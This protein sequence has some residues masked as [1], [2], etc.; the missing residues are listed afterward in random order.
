MSL[1]QKGIRS[2]LVT[3]NM[4]KKQTKDWKREKPFLSSALEARHAWFLP[5]ANHPH[6]ERG[7][8]LWYSVQAAVHEGGN[9]Y[10]WQLFWPLY[11]C[12]TQLRSSP[13]QQKEEIEEGGVKGKQEEVKRMR[14][15][16]GSSFSLLLVLRSLSSPQ[17]FPASLT[18]LVSR[19]MTCSSPSEVNY[20]CN[21]RNNMKRVWNRPDTDTVL[22]P[23]WQLP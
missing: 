1:I 9:S 2:S 10:L 7:S 6:L 21:K 22:R 20:N 18:S 16:T 13:A 11:S 14:E 19:Q 5:Q 15:M 23:S 12:L 4:R 3:N 17:G 8:F